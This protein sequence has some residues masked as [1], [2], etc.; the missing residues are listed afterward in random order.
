MYKALFQL[1]STKLWANVKVTEKDRENYSLDW[2][3]HFLLS[4]STKRKKFY[5][6]SGFKPNLS[7]FVVMIM[8]LCDEKDI[9][10]MQLEFVTMTFWVIKNHTQ[11]H[12]DWYE[13]VDEKFVVILVKK[14]SLNEYHYSSFLCWL[15][16]H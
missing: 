3:N 2:L 13:M 15:L 8:V 16:L 12:Q 6:I 5:R 10:V 11:Y 9:Q 1:D 7:Y 14:D 4:P